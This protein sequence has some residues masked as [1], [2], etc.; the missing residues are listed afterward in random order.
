MINIFEKYAPRWQ[1]VVKDY[2]FGIWRQ[3]DANDARLDFGIKA[4]QFSRTYR[5]ALEKY[6]ENKGL[7]VY[8]GTLDGKVKEWLT[9]QDALRDSLKTM[10]DT[11]KN[12]LVEKVPSLELRRIRN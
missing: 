7:H 6:Y 12:D 3:E 5:H 8:R 2:A 9:Q 1:R 10:I 11:R 4:L